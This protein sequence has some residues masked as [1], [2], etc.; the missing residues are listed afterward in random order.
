MD[1]FA[2]A[3]GQMFVCSPCFKKR[4]LDENNLVNGAAVVGGARLVEFMRDGC[5]SVSY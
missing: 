1:N 4:R 2:A 5:P 3:G